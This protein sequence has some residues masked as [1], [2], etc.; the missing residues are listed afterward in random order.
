MTLRSL[1]GLSIVESIAKSMYHVVEIIGERQFG[2]FGEAI[3]GHVI[4]VISLTFVSVIFSIFVVM[5]SLRGIDR[6]AGI[7]GIFRL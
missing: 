4:L 3:S 7:V 6:T 1:L 2:Y 5:S